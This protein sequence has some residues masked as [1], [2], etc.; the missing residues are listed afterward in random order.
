MLWNWQAS[1]PEPGACFGLDSSGLRPPTELS[2]R[3]NLEAAHLNMPYLASISG[4]CE[5]F[6]DAWHSSRPICFQLSLSLCCH[7]TGC[8][9]KM[10][11]ENRDLIINCPFS[12]VCSEKIWLMRAAFMSCCSWHPECGMNKTQCVY[13]IKGK[14]KIDTEKKKKKTLEA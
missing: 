12:S 14:Q 9:K 4:T 8:R 10:Y 2:G 7:E 1:R 6:P 3:K 13:I 11:L 5:G